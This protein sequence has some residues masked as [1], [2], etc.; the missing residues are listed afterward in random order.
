MGMRGGA[1]RGILVLVLLAVAGA[2]HA[3]YSDECRALAER[4]DRDPGSLKVGELD[5]LRNCLGNLQ[6][7]GALGEEPPAK[8]PPMACPPP[9]PPPPPEPCPVCKVCPVVEPSPSVLRERERER[10]REKKRDEDV[11]LR[12]VL[13]PF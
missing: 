11:N 6:R 1:L 9:S 5:L 8:K 2:G 10:A 4:L 12:P 3:A 13:K 7:I